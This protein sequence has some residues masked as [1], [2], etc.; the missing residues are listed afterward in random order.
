MKY[1]S[2]TEFLQQILLLLI[3]LVLIN[4]DRG[5]VSIGLAYLF[6]A[7]FYCFLNITIV[8]W[9]FTYP[10]YVID[11]QF[12]LKTLKESYPLAIVAV[13]SMVYFNID[14]VMIGKIKGEVDAGWYGICYN[15]FFVIATLPGAF[16][17][18][19]FPAI[20]KYFVESEIL[21]KEAYQLSFKMLVGI[22]IPLSIGLFLLAE[23][24][25]N[26]LF[27]DQYS[28]SIIVLKIFSALIT[29]SYLNSLAGY[30]LTAVNRQ[31]KTA[32]ILAAI[33]CVNIGL[34]CILIPYFSYIGAACATVISEL[35]LFIEWTHK[36]KNSHYISMIR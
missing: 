1:V 6:C 4:F 15:I 14:I 25:I 17:T 21:L 29:L 24:V 31:K 33:T 28:P 13:I 20:S 23:N 16:L 3:C 19:I 18:S 12:W 9:K 26:S 2:I 8:H 11:T 27:G 22:G 10:R 7:V 34:N 32:K 35:L 30:F 36:R 5:L